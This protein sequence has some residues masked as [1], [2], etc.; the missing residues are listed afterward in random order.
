MRAE[1]RGLL[2]S[3]PRTWSGQ[4][5]HR[6]F[7]P[8]MPTAPARTCALLP[9][10]PEAAPARFPR[11]G[12]AGADR[13]GSTPTVDG[14]ACAL[15]ILR[16]FPRAS[17]WLMWRPGAL[18]HPSPNFGPRRWQGF[19]RTLSCYITPPWTAA[20][21]PRDPGSCAAGATKVSAALPDRRGLAPS[22]SWWTRRTGPGYAGV[23][24]CG[25]GHDVNSRLGSGNFELFYDR[26]RVRYS[27]PQIACWSGCWRIS[28]AP[29]TS[30]GAR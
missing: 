27:E 14:F 24:A 8:P 13:L 17:G 3:R 4:Q 10:R 19:C 21:R 25:R 12:R 18:R 28:C 26:R 30:A 5:V 16:P 22:C 2:R 9:F 23:G 6:P 15:G 7:R 29:W 11:P 1:R 20:R